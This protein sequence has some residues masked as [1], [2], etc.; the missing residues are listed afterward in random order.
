MQNKLRKLNV[1]PVGLHDI[2]GCNLAMFLMKGLDISFKMRCQ[3]MSD[4]NEYI[5]SYRLLVVFIA[6]LQFACRSGQ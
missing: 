4:S 3:L 1:I 5:G 6:A 2:T